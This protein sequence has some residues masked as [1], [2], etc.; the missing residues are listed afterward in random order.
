MYQ[1]CL[2]PFLTLRTFQ[3]RKISLRNFDVPEVSVPVP[4]MPRAM[5]VISSKTFRTN[6]TFWHSKLLGFSALYDK[7]GAILMQLSFSL[8]YSWRR[9]DRDALQ[10]DPSSMSGNRNLL[11]TSDWPNQ[12][13]WMHFNKCT[14]S[15]KKKSFLWV[16]HVSTRD[17][18]SFEIRFESESA[19]PIWF[20]TKVMGWFE[21]FQIG[22]ACPLFVV[23]KRLKPLTTLS[24]TVYK[25]ASS[26]SDPTLVYSLMCLRIGVRNL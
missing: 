5:M 21:N 8:A 26:M 4:N 7:P 9:C 6:F 20:D 15:N 3:K 23:V 12:L 14:E 10:I 18:R 1:R 25:L 19:V 2:C 24:G 22:R 16:A 17:L 11:S 13:F